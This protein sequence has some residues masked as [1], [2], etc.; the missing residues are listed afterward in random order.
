MW[1]ATVRVFNTNTGSVLERVLL[2]TD[3]KAAA[4][5]AAAAAEPCYSEPLHGDPRIAFW[6]LWAAATLA[7]SSLLSTAAY[8]ALRKLMSAHA[9][10]GDHSLISEDEST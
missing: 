8:Y 9:K 6:F 5:D 7:S 10:K 2:F 4:L 3:D 1:V